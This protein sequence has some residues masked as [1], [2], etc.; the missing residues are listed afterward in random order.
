MFETVAVDLLLRVLREGLILALLVSAPLLIGMLVMG[1]LSG[2]FS[3]VTQ[4]HDHAVGFV[5]R[6]LVVFVGLAVFGPY[7]GSQVV[8]FTVSVFSLMASLR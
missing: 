8:R 7:L 2:A 5:P 1:V 6:L 4:I 3:A